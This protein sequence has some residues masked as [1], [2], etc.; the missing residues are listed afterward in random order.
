[1]QYSKKTVP[2][3]ILV[4]IVLANNRSAAAFI[5]IES[6]SSM[7]YYVDLGHPQA[8][9]TNPGTEILPWLTIQHAADVLIAG[10]TVII[11]PGFYAERVLPQNSGE[12]G[13]LITFEASLANTVTMWGFDTVNAN[14]LRIDGFNIAT[15]YSL[16]GWTEKYGV[17]IRSDFVEVVNNHFH[18]LKAAAIQG[19]WGEDFPISAYIA[20]NTIYRSQMGI[21][22]TGE[23]WIVEN[24][25]VERLYNYGSG[26]SD[27]SRFFGESHQILGNYFHGT[28]LENEIGSAHVDCFQTFDNNGEHVRNVIIENN[29]CYDFHQGFMGEAAFYG[30]SSDLTF[31]NNIFSHAGAW[32]MSIHQIRDVTAVHNVFADIRYHGIGFRDG[33]TGVVKNNIFYNAGSN[34]WASDGGS[35]VGSHN[36]LYK[37]SDTVDPIDFPDDIANQD[38]RF[39]DPANDDYHLQLGSPAVDA[40]TNSSVT[41]DMDGIHRPQG[42]G[43]DIGAY[44][45]APPLILNATSGD[46]IIYLAWTLNVTL[47]VTATWQIEYLGPHGDQESPISKL[48]NPTRAFTL[49]GLTNYS[50]YTITVSAIYT[51]TSILSDSVRAL[52]TNHITYI[53]LVRQ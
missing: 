25:E 21:V 2:F 15:D 6:P 28:D 9:D 31:R 47:P 20:G 50:P 24:N 26:D 27:Y 8:S 30:N 36:L 4:V 52:P 14:Y 23:S 44:E 53:P 33:A 10:E 45:F 48:P 39:V 40:G 5:G 32:G 11:K 42:T 16:T 29:I 13:K 18:D 3:L 34:Y 35:V 38:P 49:T 51:T 43:Y 41:A 1:M 19:Y 17:F 7:V 12:Q 22:V 37:S 46:Q